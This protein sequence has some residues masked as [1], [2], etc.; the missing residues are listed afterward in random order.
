M[1]DRLSAW[2]PLL[3][4]AMV[5]TDRQPGPLPDWPGEIGAT[6]AALA[7]AQRPAG[8][9][10]DIDPAAADVLRAAG[11]LTV[12]GLAG[13]RPLARPVSTREPAAADVLPVAHDAG[14]D[15]WLPWT[16]DEGPDRLKQ[17]FFQRF[18]QAGLRLPHALLPTALELARGSIALRALVQ[19]LLGERGVWLARQRG[20]WQFAA[21][22]IAVDEHDPRQWTEG[23]L[24]QRKA[25]LASERARDPRAARERFV[26]ALPELPAKERAELARGLATRLGLDDEPLLDQLRSDRG[27]EVRAVALELLLRL[28]DAAHPTRAAARVAALM[29]RGALLT[30]RHW[31]IEP[32]A[33][34]GADWKA[35]QVDPVV[36]IANMG[37]RAWWLYQLVRQ[38]PLSWWT[39]HTGLGVKQ[40]AAWA[41]AGEWGE[42]LWMGWRDVL[43]RA[44][45]VAWADALLD[46]W[47][48]V[49]GH[50][51]PKDGPARAALGERELVLGIVSPAV[52][53]RYFEA[54][55]KSGDAPLA[56][57]LFAIVEACKPGE[58]VPA[59]LSAL[60]VQRVKAVL[61][62]E[63]T[64]DGA[65]GLDPMH[66]LQS[67]IG[68]ALPA[69]CCVLPL[70]LLA[71]FNDWP[72][73]PMEPGHVGRGRHEGRQIIQARR[74]L[75]AY[76]P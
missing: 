8:T 63:P 73:L 10:P 62:L 68:Q 30:G 19:P 56:S 27:Q 1:S 6:L 39:A 46:E 31:V 70:P 15:P 76:L 50:R 74:A 75:D 34:A 60:I 28:P 26:A 59:P 3:P 66:P 71:D 57:N 14:V 7:G 36:G 72:A 48:A 35:D 52:R 13:A 69:L 54:Q 20:E 37:Q 47:P 51:A 55:L 58:L 42:P 64:A 65:T 11:V 67:A 4:V 61:A 29:S 43:R 49:D 2:A 17:M 32:P 16:L 12:C 23:T 38:V 33:E 5:G 44:P 41:D 22:V 40:L 25:F 18:A 45:D 21:G 9:P 53:E 24:E